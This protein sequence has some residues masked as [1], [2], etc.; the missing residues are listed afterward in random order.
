MMTDAI[1]RSRQ[2]LCRSERGATAVETAIIFTAF[3]LLIFGILQF[4]QIFWAWNTMWLAIEE[5][6]RYAMV[7]NPTS[8]PNG[9]P[10]CTTTLDTCV[11]NQISAVLTA[12]AYP[13]YLTPTVTASC[14][15]SPCGSTSTMTV[16]GAFTF[17]FLFPALFPYGPLT[18][19][20]QYTVPLS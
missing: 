20:P 3:M 8:Y 17:N 6:G 14:N 13:S 7:Y 9:P 10:G 16:S 18:L 5:A 11:Q 15:P 19:N 1:M 4:A 12:Y 2:R